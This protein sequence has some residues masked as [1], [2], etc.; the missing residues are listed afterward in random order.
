VYRG[1]YK[2]SRL[3]GAWVGRGDYAARGVPDWFLDPSKEVKPAEPASAPADEAVDMKVEEE[4]KAEKDR[5]EKDKAAEEKVGEEPRLEPVDG[6][7]GSEAAAPS[8]PQ[9]V[10]T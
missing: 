1:D 9:T 7:Q 3:V 6:V 2:W 4:D 8:A 5:A 10:S